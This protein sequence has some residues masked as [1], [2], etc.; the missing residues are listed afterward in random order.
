MMEKR[1]LYYLNPNI[2]CEKNKDNLVDIR[3]DSSNLFITQIP[4]G[5]NEDQNFVEYTLLNKT[6][7]RKRE[8]TKSSNMIIENRKENSPF[9]DKKVDENSS[10]KTASFFHLSIGFI[11]EK[12]RETFF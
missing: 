3:D 11:D 8:H 6:K 9:L 5:K 4:K 12:Y 10:N 1:S 2:N 7:K